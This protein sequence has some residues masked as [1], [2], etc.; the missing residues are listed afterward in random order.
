MAK[1]W[2]RERVSRAVSKDYRKSRKGLKKLRE[3]LVTNKAQTDFKEKHGRHIT[4]SELKDNSPQAIAYKRSK[5]RLTKDR[6][7]EEKA[8]KYDVE[9]WR[10]DGLV[11]GIPKK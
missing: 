8:G 3:D 11:P 9:K 1:D 2:I 4:P 10:T 5:K 6:K 7:A